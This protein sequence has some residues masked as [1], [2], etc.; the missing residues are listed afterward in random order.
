MR[1]PSGVVGGRL[2]RMLGSV[3]I[4]SA[5]IIGMLPMMA[6][7]VQPPV[8]N[9]VC[10]CDPL[11][12]EQQRTRES[13]EH[14]EWR[15]A[16]RTPL[17]GSKEVKAVRGYK[18]VD[19]G[20]VNVNGKVVSGHWVPDG[21]NWNRIPDSVINA[22]WGAGGV[23]SQYLN[24][25][26]DPDNPPSTNEEY[27]A[28]WRSGDNV[29]L[30]SYGGPSKSVRYVAYKVT[31]SAGYTDWG[32]WS[33]WSTNNP[34]PETPTMKVDSRTVTTYGAWSDW[35]NVG[36]PVADHDGPT[37]D[38]SIEDVDD[39]TQTRVIEVA[40]P[41]CAQLIIDECLPPGHCP[42]GFEVK[43][44]GGHPSIDGLSFTA[45]QDYDVVILVGGPPNPGKNKDPE[46]RNKFFYDVAKGD[47]ISRE[48][49]DIS[50]V[51]GKV[52]TTT[53][54]TA[55][56]TTSTSAPSTTTSS[57]PTTTTPV[58]YCDASNKPGG[59]SLAAWLEQGG[60]PDC[61]DI[62]VGGKCGM[63]T[64][65]I[66][67]N[68]TNWD[69][70]NVA[71]ELAPA[72]YDLGNA[73]FGSMSFDEDYN[74]GF[75]VAVAYYLVGPEGDYGSISGEPN[76]WQ[77]TAGTIIVDTDC[78]PPVT[79]TSSTTSTTST[80]TTMPLPTRFYCNPDTKLIEEIGSDH[81]EYE[82]VNTYDEREDAEADQ[83]C[84]EVSPTVV[85][86]VPD[87]VDDEELPFTGFDSDILF[88]LSA[89]LL[90]AGALLLVMTRRISDEA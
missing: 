89:L 37:G 48:A 34:G 16:T 61:I 77:K 84:T 17:Y 81:P 47:V 4:L 29:S 38:D 35:T 24:P 12:Q 20:S 72:T 46:G 22:V 66:S 51:C 58:D 79:S 52:I 6:F 55:P 86:S 74:G 33:D 15:F 8:D 70:W 69:T 49:H 80:S 85:T 5:L 9:A 76:F 71:F 32:P 60:N 54:T 26:V 59:I 53:S 64:G 11:Y 2:P 68:D 65:T 87:E 42:P 50:H 82:G 67:R 19:G 57:A 10:D 28:I 3:L 44:E 56:S 62:E 88:G 41:D 75:P 73:E 31:T 21:N 30:S 78:E 63:V 90:G 83:D 13:R 36:E 39:L 27:N 1:T 18:F 14:T 7:A 23:P 25:A 45:D 40:D 43:Y